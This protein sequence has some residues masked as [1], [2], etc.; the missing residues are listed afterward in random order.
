VAVD[1]ATEPSRF[2]RSASRD[3]PAPPPRRRPRTPRLDTVAATPRPSP[4]LSAARR[5][6]TFVAPRAAPVAVAPVAPAPVPA[7]AVVERPRRGWIGWLL[8]SL[9][10]GLIAGGTLAWYGVQPWGTGHDPNAGAVAATVR[11]LGVVQL[12]AQ[13]VTTTFTVDDGS[14]LPGLAN[15]ATY[16][17]VGT[18]TASVDLAGVSASDVQVHGGVTHVTIPAAQLG[19]PVLDERLSVVDHRD[20][21]LVTQILDD[22]VSLGELRDQARSQLGSQA[23]AQ[24]VPTAAERLAAADITAALRRTGVTPVVVAV[25]S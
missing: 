20:E 6:A 15:S 2:A 24:G 17:A 1:A 23:A 8:A 7:P 3:A 5:T 12:P 18:D 19:T 10:A 16:R 25:G 22:S 21:G 13:Q 14:S 9:V 11:R 4:T